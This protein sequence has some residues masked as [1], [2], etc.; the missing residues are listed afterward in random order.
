MKKVYRSV[1]VL[2]VFSILFT[3][4]D[5]RSIEELSADC[6]AAT[7]KES[8]VDNSSCNDLMDKIESEMPEPK[9][10]FWLNN[11][12]TKYKLQSACKKL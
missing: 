4:C 11:Y 6:V 8:S 3:G 1:F 7:I 9:R 12:C 2:F 10:T 5:N